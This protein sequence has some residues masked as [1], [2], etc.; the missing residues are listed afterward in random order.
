[1]LMNKTSIIWMA[2]ACFVCPA[3]LPVTALAVNFAA[4]TKAPPGYQFKLF[5]FY[6]GADTRTNKDGNPAVT[7]LGLKKYGVFIGNFFQIGALQFSALVP[8]GKVEIGKLKSDD[9]GIG[10]VQ[11]RAGWN[12]PVEWASILPTLMVKVPSGSF[13]KNNK[14]NFGDGQTDLVAELYFF[15]LLQPFSFDAL[16]KY[17]V[18]L[19]NPDS[20]VTPGNE[21]SAEGLVT[22]RLA[23]RI[24]VGPAINFIIGEDNKKGGNR[25]AD[26]GLMRLA[27]GGEIWYG[28][29][30][31]A[32]ISLAA[33][34]DMLTRNTNEG[35][36]VMSRIA[37]DF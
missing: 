15:K 7:D 6:Y 18:R 12:L 36:M 20:D 1:M 30:D 9:G 29:L 35:V 19:R 10:D 4:A 3:L 37:F 27:A 31:H 5:P 25:L 34:Q 32:R 26:S 13:D 33:Y 24:R 17:N 2:L 23:E 21:F 11:L 8:V 22:M 14:A 16:F 28:R